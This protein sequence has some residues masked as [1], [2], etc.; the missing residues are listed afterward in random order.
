MDRY[1]RF[2]GIPPCECDY[3]LGTPRV[4]LDAVRSDKGKAWE[5]HTNKKSVTSYTLFLIMTQHEL[6]KL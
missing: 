3:H 4:V 5:R 2:G 6:R 1:K